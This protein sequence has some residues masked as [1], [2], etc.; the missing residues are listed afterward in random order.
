MIQ[1]AEPVYLWLLLLIPILLISVIYG[2]VQRHR[3]QMRF[4]TSEML[5]VIMPEESTKRDWWRAILKL[6]ALGL[7]VLALARPQLYTHA[8]ISA[9]QSTG[10]DVVFCIDVSNSMAAQDVK[11][12]R[13]GFAKQI[14]THTMQ[15]LSGSRVA[16]VIFA[17][18]AYI[19]LPLTADLSTAQIFLA[20]IQPGM[21]SNQGTNLGQALERSAQALGSPS[22]AGKSV[23]M[24]TD[25]EDHEGGLEEGIE[26]LKKQRIKVYVVTIGLPDGAN[27]PIGGTL[28]TDSLGAPVLSKPNPEITAEIANATGGGSFVGSSPRAIS[29]K[30]V[31]QLRTL[32]QASLS[33]GG[34]QIEELYALPML[35][36]LLLLILANGI[37]RRKS[38]LFSRIQIFGH[39]EA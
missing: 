30:L 5:Q 34:P 11:P 19:R 39:H 8:P 18:G 2:V 22:Q 35:V 27:I 17:G 12:N 29:D 14:V 4:A 32:P 15:Q 33:G 10:V 9:Q 7:L 24:L 1:F 21:V 23:I 20:D 6:L 36:A 38:R 26:S 28:L 31:N 13:I 3:Q 25:G 37:M 16:I